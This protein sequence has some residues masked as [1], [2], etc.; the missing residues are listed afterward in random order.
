MPLEDSLRRYKMEL[1]MLTHQLYLRRNRDLF[2]LVGDARA[3]NIFGEEPWKQ[4]HRS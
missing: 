2:K 4:T 3:Y 1:D